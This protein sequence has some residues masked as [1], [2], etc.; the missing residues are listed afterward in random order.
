MKKLTAML[1]TLVLLTQI[2][3]TAVA[4]PKGDWDAVKALENHPIAFRLKNRDTIF[5]L[6]QFV[7]DAGIKVQI[8]GKEDFASQEISVRR[9]EVEKIW[10]AKLRF[11]ERSVGNGALIGAG[12]GFG[13]AMITA[14]A[15]R[16][17]DDPP[18]G[19]G[20]FPLYGAGIGMI[21]AAFWKKKHKK[22][23]LIYSI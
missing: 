11:G 3:P 20:L 13:A 17:S 18:V 14:V 7:D 15:L 4:K 8:A 12:A 23:E 10:K 19:L 5:A 9:D 2:T 16:G 22:Q 1:V 6:L 21:V